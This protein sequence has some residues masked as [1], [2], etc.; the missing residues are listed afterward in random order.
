VPSLSAKLA[1]GELAR[2][3]VGVLLVKNELDVRPA[4]IATDAELS[5][6]ARAALLW[7]PEPDAQGIEVSAHDGVVTLTGSVVTAYDRQHATDIVA[8]I[9]GLRALDNQLR[10]EHGE[11][12]YVYDPYSDPY[13]P[14]CAASQ[15]APLQ[16]AH[17]DAEIAG[18]IREQLR[19]S[20]FLDASTISVSVTGGRAVLTGDVATTG[21]RDIATE[22]ALKGGALEV[23]NR[24]NV[25]ASSTAL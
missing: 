14:C 20:P 21:E 19:W 9:A 15:A 6:R 8:G 16:T 24:V 4:K 10:V 2:N 12:H 5:E 11:S 17:T 23:D 7:D 25:V 1:A 22:D 13:A 18:T 3:T